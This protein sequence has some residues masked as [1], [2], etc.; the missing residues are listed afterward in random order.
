MSQSKSTGVASRVGNLTPFLVMELMSGGTLREW[1]SHERSLEEIAA[2][3]LQPT[4]GLA[5][6]G[7]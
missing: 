2:A 5:G 1:M 6:Q 4:L 7:C 3:L